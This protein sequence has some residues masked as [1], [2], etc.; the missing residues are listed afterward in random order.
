MIST[1]MARKNGLKIGSTFT[2]YGKTLTVAAIFETDNASA[3]N[4]VV[5]SLPV[6]QRLTGKPVRSAPPSS[7]SPRSPSSH[8]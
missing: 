4:T 8:R 7:A 5:T 6:L 2:A 3:G 1:A